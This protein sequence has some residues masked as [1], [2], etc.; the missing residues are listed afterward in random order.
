MSELFGSVYIDEDVDVL[1][2]EL[3]R[4]KGFDALTAR[5]AGMLHASDDAQLE[6]AARNGMAILTHNYLDFLNLHVRYLDMGIPHSGV[7]LID[8]FPDSPYRIANEAA[9]LLDYFTA[10]EMENQLFYV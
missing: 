8:R 4:A 2:G 5:D 1:V 7:M 9:D 3:L 6:F 10:D